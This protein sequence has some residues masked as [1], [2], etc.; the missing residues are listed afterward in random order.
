MAAA[1]PS[2]GRVFPGSSILFLCDMQEK[3]RHH[4][5]YFPQIVSVA[6][7]MLRV[8][9]LLE[10]PALLTEQ[11]PE[12]LGPTVPELGA[13][14]L[15]PLTKTCFS[16]VPALQQELDS[17]RQLRSVLL[18]GIETQACI[19]NTALDLLDQGL[20]VHVVVDA[21]SSRSQVDRLVALARMR[22]S[23]AFLSTSEGLILQLVRDA[24]HPKFK[25][26]SKLIKEPAPDSGLLSLFQG[27]NS[28]LQ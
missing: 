26:I 16:M 5:A 28:L 12:G 20:Q 19:L 27:Q 24:A 17:R 25:E 15:R 22:Q 2:L 10:V 21:C 13:E 14:G 3:F 8:A 18:C 9:Q 23:G 11:Y 4:I 6:A 1:K 7:R